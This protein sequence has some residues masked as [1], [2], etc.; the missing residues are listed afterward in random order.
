MAIN[1]KIG[2]Q[3]SRKIGSLRAGVVSVVN[4]SKKFAT[5]S[6]GRR[7]P[8]VIDGRSAVKQEFSPLVNNAAYYTLIIE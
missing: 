4:V 8:A 1:I 2:M 5:L 7:I 6:D 3:F